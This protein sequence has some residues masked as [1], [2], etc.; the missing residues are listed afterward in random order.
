MDWT[1]ILAFVTGGFVG[2]TAC[3]GGAWWLVR[4][5]GRL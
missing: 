4:G 2:I 3:I 5:V 1:H